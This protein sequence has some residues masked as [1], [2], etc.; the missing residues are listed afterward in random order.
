MNAKLATLAF[1]A[2]AASL[3]TMP[4]TA[5]VPEKAIEN[6][7]G[8]MNY[9]GY[10]ADPTT[11][12]KYQDGVYVMD[13]RIWNSASSTSGCL[14]G[15]KYSVY[16][17]DGYFNVMLGDNNASDLTASDGVV[18]TYKNYELWKALWGTYSGD[19]DRYLGVTIYQNADGKEV[20]SPKEILPRQQLLSSPFAFRAQHAQYADGSAGDFTVEGDLSV[21]GTARYSGAVTMDGNATIGK[22]S[23]TSTAVKLGGDSATAATVSAIPSSLYAASRYLY[24]YSYN[25]TVLQPTAG[26]VKISVPSGYKANVTGAGSFV[27]DTPVNTIGGTST[28]TIKG[29]TV[30]VSPT[31]ATTIGGNTVQISPSTSLYLNPLA[32][33]K[34]GTTSSS[35]SPF[36]YVK[37]T[38]TI[39]KGQRQASQTLDETNYKYCVVGWKVLDPSYLAGAVNAVNP[40]SGVLVSESGVLTVDLKENLSSTYASVRVNVWLLGIH[41]K[42]VSDGR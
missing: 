27:S 29:S 9:Q 14:W 30:S 4:A 42:L 5:A 35:Y 31:G 7:P 13:L 24:L 26:H 22:I 20:S 11:G 38:V 18:P 40:I 2:L 8:K 41:K 6:T 39:T 23:T 36:T 37:K 28:T 16:V 32:G 33:V 34:M 1:A 17:K 15:G 3:L 25:D 21:Y 10:L 19:A 12:N